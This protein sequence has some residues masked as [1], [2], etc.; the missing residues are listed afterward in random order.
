MCQIWN[1]GSSA[2]FTLLLDLYISK[3]GKCSSNFS[4]LCFNAPEKRTFCPEV[5]P[6]KTITTTWRQF[7]RHSTIKP[8]IP[9]HSGYLGSNTLGVFFPLWFKPAQFNLSLHPR[10]EG[11]HWSLC[12]GTEG[13]GKHS[14]VHESHI[15]AA[16]S[17]RI[18][19]SLWAL[20]FPQLWCQGLIAASSFN[21]NAP[22]VALNLQIKP[23][24]MR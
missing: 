2:T 22:I 12:D 11:A 14:S 17:E 15:C 4:Q 1:S 20:F 13:R 7:W 8:T 6:F 3:Q 18:S 5:L 9:A 24:L 10:T 23:L 16:K 21:L 19:V